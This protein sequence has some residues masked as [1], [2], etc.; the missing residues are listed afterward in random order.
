MCDI[1]KTLGNIQGSL[2]IGVVFALVL[3]AASFAHISESHLNLQ[4][5]AVKSSQNHEVLTQAEVIIESFSALTP[6]EQHSL[7]AFSSSPGE[8]IVD[9]SQ[10]AFV[11]SLLQNPLIS[12]VTLVS[13]IEDSVSVQNVNDVDPT[14]FKSFDR[15]FQFELT[16]KVHGLNGRKISIERVILG[17]VII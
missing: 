10:V 3:L 14:A 9:L 15:Y 1:Q 2:S 12:D 4:A 7:L 11:Q 17:E 16:T 5:I 8:P 13:W 6:E